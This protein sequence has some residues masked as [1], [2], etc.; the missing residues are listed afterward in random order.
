M[1]VSKSKEPPAVSVVMPVFNAARTLKEAVDSV[2]AQTFRDFELI[3]C[4][5]ASTDETGTILENIDDPRLRVVNNTSNLG[6][7]PARD[8]AIDRAQGIMLAVIDADDAWAPD[9][10]ATLWSEAQT[11]KNTIVFDDIME[12]HD[13][14]SG[15]VP[16]RPLRGKHAFGAD[17]DL[18]INVS[19]ESYVRS[20]RLLIKP[21]LPL[22]RIKQHGIR[23]SCI[24]GADSEF[25]LKMMAQGLRPKYVPKPMYYYRIT[26]GSMTSSAQRCSMLR[27]SLETTLDAFAHAP[28]VQ[29]ALHEKISMVRRD[30]QYLPFLR[31]LKAIQFPGALQMALHSPWLVGELLS[32]LGA[33]LAYH[34]HR[35]RCGGRS[36]GIR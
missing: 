30:E 2:F 35:I 28:S 9:R 12:C 13:T 16:W 17:G 27:Q 14:P 25:F 33:T 22:Y 10:L 3:A 34:A 26:P 32:R 36:R 6:E 1:V 4:N 23:H 24:Y 31:K 19:I 8:R 15:L 20:K 11:S 21:L 29:A 18:P 5:D 7:G